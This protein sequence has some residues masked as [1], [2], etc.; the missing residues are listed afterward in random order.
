MNKI[1]VKSFAKIN[2]GLNVVSKRNDGFHDLETVFLPIKL[3]DIL[4]YEKAE[5]YCF[6]SN[7]EPLL[8]DNN[9][10]I[11]KAKSALEEISGTTLNV[12]IELIKTTPIGAGLGGGSSNC[13]NTLK[14][15][16]EMFA[17]NIDNETLTKTALKLGSDV[18]FFLLSEPC[19]ATGRGENME[20]I[21]FEIDLPVLIINPGI[22]VSTREAFSG[23]TP[24]KPSSSLKDLKFTNENLPHL[25][26]VVKNDFEE[27]IFRLHPEIEEIK[28]SLYKAG[29]EF[30]IMTGTG[31]TVFGVFKTIQEA[32][33]FEQKCPPNYFTFI[34]NPYEK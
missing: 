12:K 3:H 33:I 7:Y 5:T 28:K 21:N 1:R 4:V 26:E 31:S 2:F 27:T 29:A 30:A 32:K 9:N 34:H 17:L 14:T 10:L 23:I 16:N 15:L 11:T 8:I 6:T 20:K 22:H 25:K 19:F 24:K 18:P 13:A